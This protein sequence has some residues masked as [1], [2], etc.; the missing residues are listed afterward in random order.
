MA[1]PPR[2]VFPGQPQHIIQRGNNWQAIFTCDEDFQFFRDAVVHA[3]EQYGLAIHAYVWMS[4]SH[5]FAGH[6]R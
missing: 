4:K 2:Y 5:T 3:S 1:R 6:P